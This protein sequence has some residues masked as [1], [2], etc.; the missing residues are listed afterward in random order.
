MDKKIVIEE[1]DIGSVSGIALI[2][3]ECFS[4]P[5]SRTAIAESMSHEPWHFL[6]AKIGGEVVGYVGVYVILDEG[7]ISNIAVLPS[8]RG[9]GI[10]KMLLDAL[11]ELCLKLGCQKITLELRK[12]NTSALGLYKKCGF[13]IVGSR[14]RFYSNPTEDA[15]LM[16]K[17][18]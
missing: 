17:I 3:L 11:F 7:Q 14:P 18:L 1:A 12:S 5:W 13:E 16:D 2:E 9:R 10:G 8:F 15:I 6:V 4:T